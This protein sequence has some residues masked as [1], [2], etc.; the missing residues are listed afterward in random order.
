MALQLRGQPGDS[1]A[2]Q[3][4]QRTVIEATQRAL[5]YAHDHGVTLVSAL[6]NEDD[7]LGA[8][9]PDTQQPGLPAGH[10]A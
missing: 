10:G 3:E 5:D 2:E 7:D 6:G 4:Q 1:P 8:P 9:E